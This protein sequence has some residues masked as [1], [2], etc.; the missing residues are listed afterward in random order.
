MINFGNA[1]SGEDRDHVSALVTLRNV[2]RALEA[3]HFKPDVAVPLRINE[4]SIIAITC[5]TS[6]TGQRFDKTLQII[7]KSSTRVLDLR[8][9]CGTTQ[10]FNE[11]NFKQSTSSPIDN[12]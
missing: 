12:M 2:F 1:V 6:D 8:Q 4:Q 5:I 10:N 7:S 11:N 9:P 3:C